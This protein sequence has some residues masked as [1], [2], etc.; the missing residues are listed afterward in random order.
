MC[1]NSPK[2]RRIC[3]RRRKFQEDVHV[4]VEEEVHVYEEGEEVVTADK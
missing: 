2:K 1:K 3:P 4:Q